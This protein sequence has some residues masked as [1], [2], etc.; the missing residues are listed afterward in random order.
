[1]NILVRGNGMTNAN[2]RFATMQAMKDSQTFQIDEYKDWTLD[3]AFRKG[4]YYSNKAPGPM[5]LTF[6][7]FLITKGVADFINPSNKTSPPTSTVRSLFNLLSQVI[8]II[9]FLMF[10]FST[11]RKEKSINEYEL[12]L[13]LLLLFFGNTTSLFY[14]AFVGH[15]LAS[16]FTFALIYYLYKENYFALGLSFGL[17]LLS[18]YG[19]GLFLVPLVFFIPRKSWIDFIK[20]GLFPGALWVW[21]HFNVTGSILETA[22]KY[23]NPLFQE[24]ADNL[25]WGAI[26]LPKLSIVGELL[27]GAKRGLLITQPWILIAIPFIAL[28]II[29]EKKRN[30]RAV[31]TVSFVAFS[32]I[33][34]MNTSFN[35]WHG[36]ATAGPRYL[37]VALTPVCFALILIWRDLPRFAKATILLGVLY[38]L[39]FR[40]LVYTTSILVSEEY[41]L[42]PWMFDFLQ[43]N[44]QFKQY[45]RIL[46]FWSGLLLSMK[47]GGFFKETINQII[48]NNKDPNTS[49]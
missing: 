3:W 20:G 8:P 43:E 4:H 26:S 14:N 30:V 46:I 36:G 22:N 35:G 44:G 45:V 28:G 33:F 38:S 25:L 42:L 10:C 21:Y 49:S 31:Y 41:D 2:S 34:L 15:G 39:L 18:D 16:I 29:R 40:T 9:A 47:Y 32:L 7:F 6:P 13:L 48:H 23:T 37:C 11:L 1:M 5:L 12:Y 27:W 19:A 24:T 17:A